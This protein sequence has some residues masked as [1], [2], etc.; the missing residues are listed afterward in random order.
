MSP[1]S[2]TALLIA[3]LP[4]ALPARGEEPRV[5][6]AR[7]RQGGAVEAMFTAAG[8]PYP[9]PELLLRAFK[10]ES[11]LE[12]WAG[13]AGEPLTRVHTFKVCAKSGTLGP[14]RARG[15]GQVPEGVYAISTLN[16]ASNFHLSLKIDYPNAADRKLGAK[17]PGGEIF[18]HGSCVTIGCLPLEDEPVERL[19]LAVKDARARYGR[20]VQVQLF[21]RR[22]EGPAA[23]EG[24]GEHR[25]LWE[26]LQVAYRLFEAHRRPVRVAVDASTGAYRFG[27]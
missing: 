5:A 4:L 10:E 11:Q 14:K 6:A 23:L 7:K 13:K 24:A 22:L 19:F 26:Q 15:D 25:A 9:P 8:V 27:R 3:L 1:F 17:D 21:P 20:P 16:P 18:I 2:R 12:L